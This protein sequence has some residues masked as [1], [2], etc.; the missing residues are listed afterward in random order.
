MVDA[1]MDGEVESEG[2]IDD[3]RVIEG[4]VDELRVSVGVSEGLRVI[5]ALTDGD[6]VRDGVTDAEG[7]IVRL[8]VDVGVS[9]GVCDGV[10]EGDGGS[11]TRTIRL[12]P[13]YT[14]LMSVVHCRYAADPV[15]KILAGTPPPDWEK[16]IGA[17]VLG[18]S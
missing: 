2:E 12:T 3:D 13:E 17:A 9:D 10:G 5:V 1:V 7:L 8:M 15:L 4:E 6:A 14:T 16:I 18:P 11:V